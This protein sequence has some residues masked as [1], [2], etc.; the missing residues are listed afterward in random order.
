MLGTQGYSTGSIA[1]YGYGGFVARFVRE[2]VR[3]FSKIRRII[4]GFSRVH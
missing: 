4:S 3:G 2:V 1:T